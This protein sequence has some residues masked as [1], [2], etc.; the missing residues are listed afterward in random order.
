M[1]LLYILCGSDPWWR[2]KRNKEFFLMSRFNCLFL[3]I[4][5]WG[6]MKKEHLFPKG[7][8]IL[9]MMRSSE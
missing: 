7:K 5:D 2:K 3:R 4:P 8:K 6:K 9:L 1:G